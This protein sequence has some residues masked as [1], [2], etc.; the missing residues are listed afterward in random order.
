MDSSAMRAIDLAIFGTLGG[1]WIIGAV[2]IWLVLRWVIRY[3]RSNT[4]DV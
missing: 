4:G 2:F 1:L 3:E